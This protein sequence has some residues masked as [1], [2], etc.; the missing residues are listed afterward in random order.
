MAMRV[1]TPDVS[2]VDL[3]AHVS[4]DTTAE[5]VNTLLRDYAA[6]AFPN[7]LKVSDE[8]LVSMDF[9]TCPISS[10]VD[11][12]LTMVMN[13]RMVKVISWYDNEWAYSSRVV[14]LVNFIAKDL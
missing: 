9:K 4:R 13:K 14:D 12:A 2:V 11:S 5:E 3:V 10:V 7:A 8:P 1:P 6:K